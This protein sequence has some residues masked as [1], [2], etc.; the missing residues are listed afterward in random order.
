MRGIT[1]RRTPKGKILARNGPFLAFACLTFAAAAAGIFFWRSDRKVSKVESRSETTNTHPRRAPKPSPA[2]P[3]Q[4]NKSRA[5]SSASDSGPERMALS[6]PWPADGMQMTAH[7]KGRHGC[8]GMLTLKASGLQFTCP[9]DDGKSFF[10]AL[11]D[12]RGPDDDG[13]ITNGGSKYHFDM[14]PGGKREYAEQLFVAWLS[15]VR[16]AQPPQ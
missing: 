13:I 12:I 7:H 5:E 8:K 11:N 10:V 16:A 9:E 4:E 6:K 15:R 2:V 14:L 1:N 3:L